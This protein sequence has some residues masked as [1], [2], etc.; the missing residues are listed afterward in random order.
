MERALGVI[1]ETAG[2][3]N[4][5]M[6]ASPSVLDLTASLLDLLRHRCEE[7]R[8]H[9][10]HTL[11]ILPFGE[12]RRADEID[13]DHGRELALVDRIREILG[14]A[15]EQN[16]PFGLHRAAVRADRHAESVPDWRPRCR[17][18]GW[19]DQRYRS[20]PV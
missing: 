17:P 3:P 9:Q 13:E 19:Q 14:R 1:L 8:L 4:T 5:A 11:G 16:A 10:P 12:L 20:V 18:S 6:T 2:A 7:P 15:A